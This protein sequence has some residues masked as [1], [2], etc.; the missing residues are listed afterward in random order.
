MYCKI[1]GNQ[2]IGINLLSLNICNEC[3]DEITRISIFDEK[4][5]FY[6]D[7][8]RIFFGYYISDN[9]LLNPVS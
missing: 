4:Y 3:I 8:I 1:C 9:H 5:D 2:D 7:C 6:K